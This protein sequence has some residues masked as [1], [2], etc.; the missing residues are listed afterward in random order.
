MKIE[1]S[2]YRRLRVHLHLRLRLL[3]PDR[4]CVFDAILA[5]SVRTAV[6]NQINAPINIRRITDPNYIFQPGEEF[7]AVF[8]IQDSYICFQAWLSRTYPGYQHVLTIIEPAA[9]A[10]DVG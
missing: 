10:M 2:P 3:R 6:Q 1:L 9:F 5:F 7:N 8:H 4:A